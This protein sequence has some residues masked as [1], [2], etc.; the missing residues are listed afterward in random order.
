MIP[1]IVLESPKPVAAYLVATGHVKVALTTFAVGEILKLVVERVFAISRDKLMLIPAFGWGYRMVCLVWDWLEA[2]ETCQAARRLSN[3]A[4]YAVRSH[5]MRL[6][7]T[8]K[9][10]SISLQPR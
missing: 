1:L 6:K 3:V 7:A 5:A 4:Q 8:Q 9:P 10:D 2:T